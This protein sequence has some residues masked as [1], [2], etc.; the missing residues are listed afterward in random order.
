MIENLATEHRLRGF[1]FLA[2]KLRGETLIKGMTERSNS[3]APRCCSRRLARRR[4]VMPSAGAR[5]PYAI[6][7]PD[8]RLLAPVQG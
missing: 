6:W 1:A 3:V 8:A 2:E 4:P 7:R 5:Y